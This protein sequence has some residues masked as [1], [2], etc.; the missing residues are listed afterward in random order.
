M[1]LLSKLGDYGPVIFGVAFIAPLV[2]QSQPVA[3][4][5]QG[6]HTVD[7]TEPG[8]G[9][10][11]DAAALCGIVVEQDYLV[12]DGHGPGGPGDDGLLLEQLRH[13]EQPQPVEQDFHMAPRD[14]EDR[15]RTQLPG[16]LASVLGNDAV[17][18]GIQAGV[19][20]I[21]QAADSAQVLSIQ[22]TQCAHGGAPLVL[23][24]VRATRLQLKLTHRSHG[25]IEPAPIEALHFA[26]PLL[27]FPIGLME[28]RIPGKDVLGPTI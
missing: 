3:G 20:R 24:Q 5:G 28:H 26:Q 2:A 21:Q 14:Q 9:H 16:N 25:V 17:I 23:H 11:G 13:S 19:E 22:G 12:G 10:L 6:H 8:I 1:T 27:S 4:V 15:A 18:D 7:Q